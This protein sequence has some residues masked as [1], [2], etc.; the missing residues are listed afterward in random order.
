MASLPRSAS[1]FPDYITVNTSSNTVN[2]ISNTASTSNSTGSLVVKGGI[3][4]TGNVYTGNIIITGTTANGI[5]FPDG[6][7]QSTAAFV[8]AGSYAY[9]SPIQ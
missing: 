6:T 2:I 9:F 8:S 1:Q 7:F 3:A 4:T 5:V